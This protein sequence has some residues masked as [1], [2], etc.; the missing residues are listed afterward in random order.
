MVGMKRLII[1]PE[2]YR[3]ISGDEKAEIF[4]LYYVNTSD[5]EAFTKEMNRQGFQTLASTV[6]T[7][8]YTHLQVDQNKRYIETKG[9]GNQ[10]QDTGKT[11]E[12]DI[13][14]RIETVIP[15]CV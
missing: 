5:E 8:S 3:E 11:F 9:D 4:G 15:R 13:I 2:D 10:I 1:N 6:T 14:G 12:T 7:V